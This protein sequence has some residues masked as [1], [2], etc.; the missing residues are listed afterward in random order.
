[1]ILSIDGRKAIWENSTF[2]HGKNSQKT[3]NR[4]EL[5]KYDEGHVQ[6]STAN[7]ILSE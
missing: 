3:R 6:K 7:I 2:A 1:M 4:G 5:S